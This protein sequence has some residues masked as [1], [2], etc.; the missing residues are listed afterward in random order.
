[1]AICSGNNFFLKIFVHFA[2]SFVSCFPL[3]V[4]E[5][6]WLAEGPTFSK[7]VCLFEVIPFLPFMTAFNRAEVDLS[8]FSESFGETA[9]AID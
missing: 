8:T 3:N 9:I 6:F 4:F 1:M 5:G 2:L 7:L